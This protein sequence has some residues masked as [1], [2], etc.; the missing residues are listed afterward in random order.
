VT[1]KYSITKRRAVSLRQLSFLLLAT[2]ERIYKIKCFLV[3]INYVKQ[4]TTRCQFY[5]NERV[6]RQRAPRLSTRPIQADSHKIND[7]KLELYSKK[8]PDTQSVTTMVLHYRQLVKP[9]SVRCVRHSGPRYSRRRSCCRGAY[10]RSASLIIA[11]A[12]IDHRPPDAFVI[13][14][15]AVAGWRSGLV[16]TRWPR[17]T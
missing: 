6:T 16:A 9:D 14:Y 2:M 12:N 10:Y 17:S 3:R 4:Q 5:L 11:S 7:R 15:F 13:T 8:T 1:A